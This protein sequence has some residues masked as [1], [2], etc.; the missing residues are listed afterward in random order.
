MAEVTWLLDDG[1]E[2]SILFDAT[3]RDSHES[4]ATIT[5]H[6]VDEGANISDHIRPDLDQVT[7]QVVV[8]NT[9][10]VSPIDHNDGVV[11]TQQQVELGSGAMASANV[12]VFDGAVTRV[13]SV[14]EAL[15]DLKNSG[16]LVNVLTSLREYESMGIKRISPI[17]EAKSGN[18]LVATV[19]FKQIRVVSSE[20]VPSPEPRQ[21]RGNTEQDRG[22]DNAEDEDEDGSTRSTAVAL[23]Q[24][25]G[26]LL[27]G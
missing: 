15:L 25:L 3:V 27:G 22:R 24:G 12:L 17:R 4:S 21:T 19:E 9:P 1:Q 6:P 23:L 20:I 11:G 8:S 10:I 16:T 26:G 2:Q 14:Y 13:R 5:E 7:L 18:S